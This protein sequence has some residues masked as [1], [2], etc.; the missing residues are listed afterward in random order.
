MQNRFGFASYVEIKKSFEKV[1][2]KQLGAEFDQWVR[3]K[4]APVIKLVSTKVE[5]GPDSYTL[6]I[7]IEQEQTEDA[8][9]LHLPVAV[10]LKG[11]AKAWQTVAKLD[12]KNMTL[13]FQLPSQPVRVDLDPE[14]DLFRRLDSKET[15]P[16]VSQVLGSDRVLI[17]LP[18]YADSDLLNGY[19][20]LSELLE[21]SA[22]DQVETVFD[23]NIDELPSDRSVIILGWENRFIDEVK[24]TLSI[25]DTSFSGENI[26]IG[27]TKLSAGGHS[28]VISG[29][30]PEKKD[31]ALMFIAAGLKEA[32]PGL[33][34][35][36]P[37]YHKYSYLAFEGSEPANILKGRWPVLDSPM[38]S[39]LFQKAGQPKPGMGALA[40][41]KPL[42]TLQEA[43]KDK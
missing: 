21:R 14:F 30:N 19:R 31:A 1:S 36:L 39:F 18:A 7:T 38:T 29:R 13:H 43:V 2:E 32:L 23:T 40:A 10:T 8:Y 5:T 34:R 20:E 28:V 24:K 9:L 15:P 6:S 37:H 27:K 3:R 26:R 11:D 33:G 22:N 42:A 17:L 35:K 4:G 41:R 25:Y 12:R 16:A